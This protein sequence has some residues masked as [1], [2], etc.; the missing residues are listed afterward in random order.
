MISSNVLLFLAQAGEP[1]QPGGFGPEFIVAMV[2]FIVAFMLLIQRPQKREQ[3]E[4]LKAIEGMK[5]GDAVVSIGGI[6]G[7]VVKVDKDKGTVIVTVARGVDLEFNK[8]AVN[9][10]KPEPK[11]QEKTADTKAEKKEKQAVS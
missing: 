1:K 8:S 9:P 5:K 7:T 3:A 10:Y 11:P 2:I 4:K 6:H